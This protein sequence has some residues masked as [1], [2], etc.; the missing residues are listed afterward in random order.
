M[1]RKYSLPHTSRFFEPTARRGRPYLPFAPAAKASTKAT[2]KAEPAFPRRHP[3]LTGGT[4]L[5]AAFVY[6][7]IWRRTPPEDVAPQDFDFSFRY[8]ATAGTF[9][10]D[11]DSI[12][13]FYGI[14]KLRKKLIQ[15]AHGNV[16]EAAAGTGRN[17]EFY[18]LNHISTISLQDQSKEMIDIAKAK[19]WET[20]PEYEHCRFITGSAL[21]ALPPPPGESREGRPEDEGYDTI[22][23]TMSLCSTLEPSLFLRNLAGHLSYRNVATQA[24]VTGAPDPREP[25]PARILLLEHGRSY[26]SWIN[27]LLDNSAPAHA[28]QHGCW[29]N[30]D[31]GQI[32]E[33]SGLEIIS[34]Q[35]KHLGTT[36]SLEL[37][38]PAE[39]KG[40]KRQQWLEDTRQKIAVLPAGGKQEHVQWIERIKERG[41][42]DR[43]SEELAVWRTEQ[44]EK[45]KKRD[46]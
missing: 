44:R 11:V 18:N 25:L 1:D 46:Q 3:W 33:D 21:G 5:Y 38:L 41:E 19:W 15:K 36:W 24:S 6:F 31:I 8:N 34:S 12:E 30:R 37:G 28:M 27:R 14:P 35:R 26:F 2:T 16:L 43:R 4:V 22:V 10:Q 42:A 13:W 17:S 20:H 9:D 7:S 32:I 29:R 23:A 39:A 40:E 45:M